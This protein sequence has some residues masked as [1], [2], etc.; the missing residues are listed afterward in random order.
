MGWYLKPAAPAPKQSVQ[1]TGMSGSMSLTPGERARPSSAKTG[2][3]NRANSP[4]APYL[5]MDGSMNATNMT[6]AIKAMASEN[7]PLKKTA[8]LTAILDQLT[9][10][11]AKAAF[12]AMREARR[13]QRGGWGR[14][15]GDEMRLL[16]NAWGR[17]DGEAAISEL[18]ALAE[19]E[20]AE[21]EANGGGDRGRGR[22]GDSTFDIYSVLSGWATKDSTAALEYVNSLE[23]DDR[24]K[25]MYTSGIVR[26]LMINGV[27]DAVSFISELPSDDNGTRARYM[28][29]VAEEMLEQGIDSAAQWADSLNDDELKGGAM[30]RI[31]G[32]YA[33]TDLDAAIEWVSE[34]APEDYARSAVTEIAEEWAEKDPQSVIDWA[35]DLPDATQKHVFEEALDEWT[36]RDPLAASEYLAE[37]PA[38]EVKDSAVEGFAKE[39]A[40]EDPQAAAAW[41]ATI[42]NDEIRTSTLMD[43]ARNWLRSDRAAAE[44][45]LPDSGL[46]AEAQQSIMQPSEDRWGR[47]GDRRGRG[48]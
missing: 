24:R 17:I 21:R 25:G 14:G 29:T 10:E 5:T 30:D 7:D 4:I 48:R 11:N 18:T 19:A 34:H 31:A 12:E 20:R 15:G 9:P 40:R 26:G 22:G 3:G 36:E 37:M 1:G 6:G 27:D 33:N 38:S 47:G 39:L 42:G 23:G 13:N 43:V 41:G 46:S 35:G 32:E 28:S 2:A 8:M 44:A 16:L 45:W